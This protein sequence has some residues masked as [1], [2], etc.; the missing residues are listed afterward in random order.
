MILSGPA[1]KHRLGTDIK[2]EPY[3]DDQLNPNSYNLRLHE[4][5]LVYSDLPLDMKKKQSSNG[6]KNSA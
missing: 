6:I 3:S 4:D 2:I 1:I 5:L